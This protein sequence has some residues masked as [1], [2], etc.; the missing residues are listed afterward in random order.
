MSA[1]S[2]V[3]ETGEVL[4][5]HDARGAAARAVAN[6]FGLFF[7]LIA[8]TSLLLAFVGEHETSMKCDRASGTC[9]LTDRHPRSFP[10]TDLQGA[11]LAHRKTGG[12]SNREYLRELT[13]QHGGQ[14]TLLCAVP[15]DDGKEL[16]PLGAKIDAFVSTPGSATLDVACSQGRTSGGFKIAS[17]ING[18]IMI[19]FGLFA[20]SIG[21]WRYVTIDRDR[22]VVTLKN[23]VLGITTKTVIVSTA[24]V[25]AIVDLRRGP[26]GDTAGAWLDRTDGLDELCLGT[27]ATSAEAPEKRALAARVAAWL[28]RPVEQR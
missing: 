21:A 2:P 26:K 13:V 7:L 14:G 16:D 28:G 11:K 27:P 10:V 19:L 22:G 4:S 8:A 9:V 3:Q 1:L 6:G 15:D 25:R 17:V 18:I 20:L 5:F 12:R 23:R 24:D